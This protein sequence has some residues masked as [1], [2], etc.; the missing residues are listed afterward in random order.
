MTT[1][2]IGCNLLRFV[3]PVLCL[4]S[5][6][7][8]IFSALLITAAKRAFEAIVLSI[9]APRYFAPLKTSIFTEQRVFKSSWLNGTRIEK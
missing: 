8:R 5:R 4:D 2:T 6:A 9:N 7:K 3:P 1:Y